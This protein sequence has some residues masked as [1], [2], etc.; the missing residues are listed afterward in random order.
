MRLKISGFKAHNHVLRIDPL[1]V[2]SASNGA[3]KSAVAESVRFLALGYVPGLGKRPQDTASLLRGAAM[4]VTLEL[5]D[6]RSFWRR[7]EQTPKGYRTQAR[8][9]WVQSKSSTV[10][11]KE[12]LGL[13]GR[14]EEEVAESLDIRQLLSASPLQR[15]ARIAALLASSGGGIEETRTEA[16]NLARAKG[17]TEAALG[18]VKL[19][20]EERLRDDGLDGALDWANEEKRRYAAD[21]LGKTHADREIEERLSTMPRVSAEQLR[22]LEREAAELE[23]RTLDLRRHAQREEAARIDVLQAERQELEAREMRREFETTSPDRA[24]LRRELTEIDQAMDA[25]I[26]PPHEE[27]E[28]CA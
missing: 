12:I 6:G 11:A 5:S 27:P 19:P 14:N 2:L 10:N 25:L 7:L 9:S 26:V 3:G 4:K 21:L 18:G 16:L 22:D 23:A 17:A 15:E 20:L 8:C 28:E 13:F 24:T 1:M